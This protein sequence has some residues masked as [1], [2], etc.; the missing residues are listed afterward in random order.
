V[1]YYTK[2]SIR[3]KY[4]TIQKVQYNTKGTID[5]STIRY[6]YNTIQKVQCKYNMIKYNTIQR[7][8]TSK[9]W[10]STLRYKYN[11]LQVKYDTSTIRYK[12]IHSVVSHKI[13][14]NFNSIK[15][16][17]ILKTF[18]RTHCIS[19]TKTNCLMPFGHLV[20]VYKRILFE[21]AERL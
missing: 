3:Y 17:R 4:N 15:L 13:Y 9:I 6:R 10:W 18:E 8:N 5:T 7:Y 11:T 12:C 21:N 2:V 19:L 20:S 14:N 1:Q 16:Y